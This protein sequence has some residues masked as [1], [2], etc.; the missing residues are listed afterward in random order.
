MVGQTPWSAF[1]H[2]N[3]GKTMQRRMNFKA[4]FL[5]F[6]V[7]QLSFPRLSHAYIDPGTG[8][9]I[10]QMMIGVFVGAV[11]AVK[12]FWARIKAFFGKL[13]SRETE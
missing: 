9:Y 11:F 1:C 6:V 7:S 8:S 5:V 3:G 13:F 4:I 10:F 12:L 2:E